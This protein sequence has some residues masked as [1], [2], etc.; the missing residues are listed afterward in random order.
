MYYQLETAFI[1][2]ADL[3]TTWS[4]FSRAQ[5]LPTITPPWLDFRLLTPSPITL[6]QD[7]IM[8]YTIRW[9]GARIHWRTRIID[10]SPPHQ[11][12]DLQ[13]RGPYTLW[14]HQHTFV[15]APGGNGTECR[16]RV[17]YKL[18]G[19]VL[20]RITHRLAVRRQ[21]VEIF[22]YRQQQVAN[23]LGL[24]STAIKPS[25]TAIS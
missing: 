5:N 11:F 10:W 6:Q 3:Q 8:D 17:V 12:I 1:V 24:V 18:P 20:G 21:L 19:M 22:E 15:P 25:V 4:F 13:I 2:A 7:S 16:D 14:H 9:L 23:Q